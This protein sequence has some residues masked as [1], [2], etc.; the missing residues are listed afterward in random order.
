MESLGKETSTA[1][2]LVVLPEV[3]SQIEVIKALHVLRLPSPCYG[4]PGWHSPR[5]SPSAL[6]HCAPSTQ[7]LWTVA[8]AASRSCSAA[9]GNERAADNAV[10]TFISIV[11]D[12]LLATAERCP[13]KTHGR[14][15]KQLSSSPL[16]SSA[17]NTDVTLTQ[18]LREETARH[19]TPYARRRIRNASLLTNAS[20]PQRVT[21]QANLRAVRFPAPMRALH[22]SPL[23][24]ERH[25]AHA[26][27]VLTESGLGHTRRTNP[28]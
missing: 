25:Y 13:L 11:V 8:S 16:Q 23:Y 10:S 5:S 1:P 22:P 24:Y 20:L 17:E 27:P 3:T 12:V 21:G 2:R 28:S 4:T 14:L 7:W 19:S 6:G 18:A 9:C 26:R 15:A